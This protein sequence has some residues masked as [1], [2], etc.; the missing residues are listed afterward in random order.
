MIL[1]LYASVA[2][3]IETQVFDH[4]F[5]QLNSTD[6]HRIKRFI[7]WQDAHAT[8]GGRILLKLGAEQLGIDNLQ[9][10]D[11]QATKNGKPFLKELQFNISHSGDY[12]AC[13]LS[14]ATGMGV[15]IEQ[16]KPMSFEDFH[17]QFTPSEWN[18]INNQPEH[19]FEHWCAK[20]AFIKLE[21][22]GLEIP[23]T[24]VELKGNQ[25]FYEGVAHPV[26]FFNHLDGYKM[27]M[28][29][30]E[31]EAFELKEIDFNDLRKS[32]KHQ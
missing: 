9:L 17:R 8:L 32:I 24:Q 11:L 21:G 5:F 1:I 3:P 30:E 28:V 7:R 6:Q 25:I 15:D 10:S 29:T 22:R 19:F 16:A 12:V 14:L 23:L 27:A 20:E 13:A 31:V 26:Q 2:D 4:Y 18:N